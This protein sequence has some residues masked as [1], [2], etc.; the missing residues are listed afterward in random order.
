[1]KPNIHGYLDLNKPFKSSL[2]QA[3]LAGLKIESIFP[4]PLGEG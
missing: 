3:G 4:L 2:Y 1:M